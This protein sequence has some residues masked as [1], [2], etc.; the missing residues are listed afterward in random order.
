MSEGKV[1]QSRAKPPPH[2]QWSEKLIDT[3]S[4]LFLVNDLSLIPPNCLI[5]QSFVDWCCQVLKTQQIH[6]RLNKINTI[7]QSS[8][9][10]GKPDLNAFLFVFFFWAADV[11][12]LSRLQLWNMELNFWMNKIQD[13]TQCWRSL[14]FKVFYCVCHIFSCIFWRASS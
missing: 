8:W 3:R 2:L 9:Q 5:A 1:T 10:I 6:L 14:L 12:D 11:S 4:H 13:R 7:S